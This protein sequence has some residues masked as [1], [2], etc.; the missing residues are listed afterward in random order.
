MEMNNMEDNEELA[1]DV[2]SLIRSSE[3]REFLQK[4]SDLDIFDKEQIV[5]HS[6]ISIQKKMAMLEQLADAGNEEGAGLIREMHD[7]LAEYLDQIFHPAVRT[8][9]MLEDYQPYLEGYYIKEDSELVDA[10]DTVDE[11]IK[12]DLELYSLKGRGMSLYGFA[13]VVQVP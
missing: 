8:I 6:Y 11:M 10:Y 9:F 2:F 4:E 7:I 3:V 1:A 12:K 13:S 5:L